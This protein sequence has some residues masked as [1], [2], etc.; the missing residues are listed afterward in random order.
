MTNNEPTSVSAAS[1][2]LIYFICLLNCDISMPNYLL[3]AYL[4]SHDMTS[5]KNTFE[6]E[7]DKKL[8]N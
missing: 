7:T 5:I 3:G 8:R 6:T 1:A 2:V 4:G